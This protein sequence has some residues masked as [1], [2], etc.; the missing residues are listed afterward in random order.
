VA[1]F[2]QTLLRIGHFFFG[3]E[4]F[5]F[6]RLLQTKH[7]YDL[8]FDSKEFRHFFGAREVTPHSQFK[9][10]VIFSFS[11]FTS[12]STIAVILFVG[13]VRVFPVI[14]PK[15]IF[16]LSSVRR[17]FCISFTWIF[18]PWIWFNSQAGDFETLFSYRCLIFGV[19]C[20][21]SR[22]V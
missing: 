17:A 15:E 12:L 1:P 5:G 21:F 2:F 6:S 14:C 9:V 7:F 10:Q 8:T 11:P 22:R 13:R 20:L 18:L 19:A 16:S 3:A 4:T